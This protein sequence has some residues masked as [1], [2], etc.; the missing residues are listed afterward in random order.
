MQKA[1]SHP[2]GLLLVVSVWFQVLFHSPTRR[3]FHLSLTVL[4]HYRSCTVFSLTRWCWQ[5]HTGFLRSRA[6]QGSLA[7]PFVLL[8]QGFHLLW[9]A[10]QTTSNSTSG[11]VCR[12][13][14]PESPKR[15]GLG[16]SPFARHYLGNHYCFLF[17]RVLRCFSS[18]GALHIP[19]Y[20]VYDDWSSTSRVSP[21]G[22]HRI[23]ACLQLPMLIAAYHVLHRPYMPRHPPYA[24]TYLSPAILH[25]LD[26]CRFDALM[27]RYILFT[28]VALSTP[29]RSDRQKDTFIVV[30]QPHRS[31]HKKT[32]FI[33]LIVNKFPLT[34]GQ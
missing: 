33:S 14:N 16:C 22:N 18:P 10:F 26:S 24:I 25:G 3:S 34:Q 28:T 11:P 7:G 19:M 13:Y 30:S 4:V 15:F 27:S 20:S 9:R 29:H 2:E 12:P 32:A 23:K 21:F 6:T 8:L 5:I 31:D 1:R 17:L